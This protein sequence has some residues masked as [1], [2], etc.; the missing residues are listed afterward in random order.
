[1]GKTHPID[2]TS[3][4]LAENE[5]TL[6]RPNPQL[7]VAIDSVSPQTPVPGEPASVS[8]TLNNAGGRFN[9]GW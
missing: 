8:F 7:S 1:M 6:V 4:T 3:S 9:I 5:L 2:W